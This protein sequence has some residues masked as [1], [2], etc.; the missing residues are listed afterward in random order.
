MD[1]IRLPLLFW[2]GYNWIRL[3]HT[4]PG[5]LAQRWASARDT[6]PAAPPKRQAHSQASHEDAAPDTFT[7]P[8]QKR[9]R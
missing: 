3:A 1:R 8:H 9:V 2:R 4:T 7:P 6:S 5:A